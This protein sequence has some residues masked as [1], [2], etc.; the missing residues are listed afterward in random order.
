MPKEEEFNPCLADAERLLEEQGPHVL[1]TA[2]AV[3]DSRHADIA[4]AARDTP[5]MLTGLRG[6]TCLIAHDPEHTVADTAEETR[7]LLRSLLPKQAEERC[8]GKVVHV[9]GGWAFDISRRWGAM[10]THGLRSGRISAPFEVKVPETM[11]R[12]LNRSGREQRL[13][14][15][16]WLSMR[17][18]AMKRRQ[19]SGIGKHG[20]RY[21]GR[22]PGRK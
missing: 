2:M 22:F 17:R 16:P 4:S 14:R 18:R 20:P 6:Y 5:S 1:A 7:Q 11:P 19:V 21:D 10:L 9:V 8:I 15:V 12:L 13:R 3:L